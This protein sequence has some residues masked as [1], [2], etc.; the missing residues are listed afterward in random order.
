MKVLF[1]GVLPLLLL[2]AMMNRT[3][4]QCTSWA[5]SPRETEIKEAH[6]LYRQMV[7]GKTAAEL[8][9][10]DDVTFGIAYENWQ[11]AYELAPMADGQRANHFIDGIEL[12]KAKKE[13]SSDEATKQAADKLILSLYDQM[14]VCYPKEI[15]YALSW[16]ERILRDARSDRGKS[17]HLQ[18][19]RRVEYAGA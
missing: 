7:K 6:V 8:A 12:N 19:T 3:N 11:K 14:V 18:T 5:G 13:R 10:M 2:I 4:A 1:S 17:E 16:Q 15:G 9:K